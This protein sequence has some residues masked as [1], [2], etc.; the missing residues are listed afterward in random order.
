[1]RV[2]PKQVSLFFGC[3]GYLIKDQV[4]SA[5]LH[6]L[7]LE[8]PPIMP[9]TA[10]PPHEAAL[11]SGL[12]GIGGDLSVPSLMLAYRNGIF[13]WPQ[14]DEQLLW[15]SPPIRTVL[16]FDRLHIPR[17]LRRELKRTPLTF[18]VNRAFKSVIDHCSE[19]T[20]RVDQ[21]GTWIT[22]GMKLA[23]SALHQAGFCPSFESWRADTL[24]GGMYG[25]LIDNFF[26]GESMFYREPNISKIAIIRAIEYLSE[27]GIS[28][29]DCQMTTPLVEQL[30]A[31]EI[32]REEYLEL[33]RV[34]IKGEEE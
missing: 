22:P 26:A 4:L 16:F 13:P 19:M 12:I 25:V 24:I 28:W 3:F 29:M 5:L 11:P 18:G 20:N 21:F 1:M 8:G 7:T 2:N 27:R 31:E 14:S 6:F 30:G 15:F 34:A 33:L 32:P 17:S 23:Y 10:F 9:I